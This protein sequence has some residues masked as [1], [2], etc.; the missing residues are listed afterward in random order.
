MRPA[1]IFVWV[2]KER[3]LLA[4]FFSSWASFFSLLTEALSFWCGLACA[5]TETKLFAREGKN[6]TP[7]P[8]LRP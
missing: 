8:F 6:H 4:I 2:I 3:W 7:L 5:C 1:V